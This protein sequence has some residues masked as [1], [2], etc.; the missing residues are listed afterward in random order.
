M[1]NY[2][3]YDDYKF[4]FLPVISAYKSSENDKLVCFICIS[5][6]D[7]R[8]FEYSNMQ[9]KQLALES[10][11]VLYFISWSFQSCWQ[12]NKF[13]WSI[14]INY[15]FSIYSKVIFGSSKFK[16]FQN[17]LSCINQIFEPIIDNLFNETA[18]FNRDKN[19]Q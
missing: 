3:K 19:S 17:K 15:V 5:F 7:S 13:H 11:V 18:I 12:S 16:I 14:L 8:S 1:Y 10:C 6:N 4:I 9:N 2:A